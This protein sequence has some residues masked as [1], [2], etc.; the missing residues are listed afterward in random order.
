LDLNNRK[1]VLDIVRS[2]LGTKFVARFGDLICNMAIEAVLKI[3]TI[4]ETKKK[5]I[6]VKRYARV[7]KISGGQ[8]EDSLVL[9]GVA[10]NK[11]VVDAKM[12]RRIENP[13]VL[14]LDCPL[15]YRKGESQT[16]V[17]I[18]NEKDF[19][20]LLEQEEEY[21]KKQCEEIL[22]FN[23][24]V[25]MTEKGCSDLA[26]HYLSKAG[27]SVLRRLKKT[28]NNR[29]SRATGATICSETNEIKEADIGTKCG[30]FEIKKIGDEYWAFLIK[31]KEPKACT[32]M[33]RGAS[34]EVLSE[35]ERNL[36]DAMSV[37]R[38]IMFDPQVV[39][40]GGAIEMS[41]EQG[42][43]EKSKLI[44][45]VQQWPY[46]AAAQALEVI[47]RTLIENCG[48][49]TIRIL[50]ALRAKHADGKSFTFGVDGNKGEISDMAELQ[51][52][53]TFAVKAQTLKT[54]FEAACMLLRI[55]DIVSGISKK[56]KS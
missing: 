38:N 1:Q 44:K 11:D 51:I 27:V 32:I 17:E 56:D 14:L 53:D 43:L 47:P 4:S 25:V 41:I 21:V 12:K 46:R 37:V 23:P 9:D 49:S 22:K 26:Q 31:C 55:D 16:N 20:L 29:V 36:D 35:M 10:L 45:G 5:E 7:E 19:E 3:T 50:T 18:T 28:D 8:L 39:Y 30:L 24:Q 42:L 33:L 2:T 48:A 52:Y 54:A 40:G 6:D 34:K 15:E 13:R